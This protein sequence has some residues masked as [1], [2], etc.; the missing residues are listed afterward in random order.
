MKKYDIA[1]YVWPA[2]TGD[3]HRT[4]LFW[5]EGIGEWQTVKNEIRNYPEFS[6]KRQPVWGYVNEA[7]PSVMEMEIEEAVKYGVNVFIYDWYWYD[8][9]PF[10]ENCLNDGFLKAKNNHKMKFYLMWANHSVNYSW[11]VRNSSE[12]CG[13]EIIW[14]GEVDEKRFDDICD[15]VIEK[16]FHHPGYYTI[17]GCPV[18]MIYDVLNLVNGLGGVENTKRKLNDFR[19]KCVKSGLPG[20]HLQITEWGENAFNLSGLDIS[21]DSNTAEL[22]RV[23]G[24][25]SATNYQYAHF[26]DVNRDFRDATADASK[27]WEVFYNQYNKKYFPHVSIGW[28]NNLRFRKFRKKIM[29]NNGPDEFREALIEVKKFMDSH[30]LLSPLFTI[31]SWNEWTESSYLQPDYLNGYGYLQ[32]VKDVFLK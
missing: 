2:Y 12:D 16:Y 19:E 9:R 29:K 32:A 27:M 8:G 17:N 14:S 24:F 7:N 5:P 3:E 28:D 15:R 21:A 10:L 11:D 30:E 6:P 13:D 20:L 1:A 25:D 26:V 18:F 22:S 31:N 4:R 23:L